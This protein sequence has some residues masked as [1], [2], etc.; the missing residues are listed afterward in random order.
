MKK[1]IF[2]LIVRVIINVIGSFYTSKLTLA[3]LGI[4]QY[5]TLIL[6]QSVIVT[7]TIFNSSISANTLRELSTK[8]EEK[9]KIA[10]FIVLH[11]HI[12]VLNIVICSIIGMIL[13]YYI[14]ND[15]EKS[16]ARELL[17]V[18]T[19]SLTITF[20]MYPITAYFIV[21][22]EFTRLTNISI[23]D[24]ITKIVLI[25]LL[26][27]K[28]ITDLVIYSYTIL[29]QT[30]IVK[31]IEVIIFTRKTNINKDF[32]R[33]EKVEIKS[34]LYYIKWNLFG[35]LSALVNNQIMNII[36]SK[37]YDLNTVAARGITNQLNNTIQSFIA[38]ISNF[39]TNDIIK[40]T[41]FNK[42]GS[43]NNNIIEIYSYLLPLLSMIFVVLFNNT[44]YILDVWLFKYPSIAQTFIQIILVDLYVLGIS[45]PIHTLILNTKYL[46]KYQIIS[47]IIQA[48]VLPMILV[49]VYLNLNSS[50]PYYIS[51]VLSVLNLIYKVRLVQKYTDKSFVISL[52]KQILKYSIILI[53]LNCIVINLKKL[54][55]DANLYLVLT[56]IISSVLYILIMKKKDEDFIYF[57]KSKE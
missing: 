20:I 50:Y 36:V 43:L 12:G 34:Y 15:F 52:N 1:E 6:L 45:T 10:K 21:A 17:V 29:I 2:V 23:I 22:K 8:T 7:V 51:V 32:Y 42:L 26:S 11:F 25:F 13:L 16:E 49:T 35:S 40:N 19:L 41:K 9:N 37:F 44:E 18:N 46:K 53:A 28:Q 5:G 38:S 3:L 27:K 39:N 56:V 47:S 24:N 57:G 31:A 30:V 55:T 48:S 14:A 54:V 4:N 33:I